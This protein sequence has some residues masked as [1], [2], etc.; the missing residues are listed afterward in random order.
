MIQ[1]PEMPFDSLQRELNDFLHDTFLESHFFKPIHLAKS[2]WRPAIEMKQNEKEYDVKVQLPGVV[3]NDIKVELENDY[4]TV[5][6]EIK[7]EK[8][9]KDENKKLKS[10]EFRYGKFMRTVSFENPIK[11]NEATAEY[12]NGVLRI[13]IPKQKQEK[14]KIK[15]IEIK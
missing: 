8:E 13:K 9:E 6:A 10:S 15:Q 4:M 11:M 1:E 2:T 3:K 5:S 14:A 7:E 12:K